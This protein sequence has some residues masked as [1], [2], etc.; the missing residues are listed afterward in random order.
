[1]AKRT[2]K[3]RPA[4]RDRLGPTYENWQLRAEAAERE[5]IRLRNVID[6]HEKQAEAKYRGELHDAQRHAAG[7]DS[8]LRELRALVKRACRS[9]GITPLTVEAVSD[10]ADFFLDD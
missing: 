9:L 5:V 1:M 4:R 8:Q 3:R 6:Q 10:L 7:L 2:T